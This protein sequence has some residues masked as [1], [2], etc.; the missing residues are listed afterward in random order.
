MPCGIELKLKNSEMA[1][2]GGAEKKLK[3]K[4]KIIESNSAASGVAILVGRLLDSDLTYFFIV[5][6]VKAF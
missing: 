4:S 1:L 2:R 3:I 6:I 5:E